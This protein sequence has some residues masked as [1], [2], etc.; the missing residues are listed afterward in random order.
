ML[1]LFWLSLIPFTTATMGENSF[2]SVTVT[3]YAVV[4]IPVTLTYVFLVNQLCRLH[5]SGSEFSKAFK[6]HLKSY[7]TI[8]LNISAAIIS[9]L[10]FPK[11]AFILI[12]FIALTWFIPNHRFVRRISSEM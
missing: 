8:G 3:V 2:T 12:A 11:I 1:N 7:I 10:G 9:F 5:G 6:G 4:L